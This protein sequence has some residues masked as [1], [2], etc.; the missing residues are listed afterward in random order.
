M[1]EY[2]YNGGGVAVGDVNQD[3]LP[4]IYFTAN[5]A[6]NRL[7]L[8]KGNLQFTDITDAAGVTGR[9]GPWKTGVTMADVNGDKLLDILVCYSG[10]VRPEKRLPQLFINQGPD[11]N[12][13][14]RFRDQAAQYGLTQPAYSTNASFFDYDRD[15][16]LDL[17]LLNHSPTQLPALDEALTADMLKK[18]DTQSGVRLFRN[19]KNFFKDVTQQTG[20]HSSVL[21]YGLGIAISDV[22]TDGWP[23]LYI[24]NDYAIPDFLYI[25]NHNG[26]FTNKL[27]TSVGHTSQFSMGNEVA[28]INND[29]LP[30]ILT[31]DMLPEDN[32][33]QKLLFAPDNYEKFDLNLRS[34]FY[35]QYM[36]NMLQLN[37]GDGTFSEV[38]QLAGIS[39]TDWSWA[40]LFADY[41]ND[42]WKDLYVTNGYVRDFTNLDF[43]KYMG[44]YMKQREGHLMRDDVLKLVHQMPSSNVTNY[45][46]KNT[47]N[48]VFRDES[49]NWG[50][51][52]VSNSNGAAYADLDNDGDLDLIV[53][54]INQPASIYQNQAKQQLKNQF[55]QVKLQ[56]DGKNTQGLGAKVTLYNQG[57]QQY[58]EQMPTRGFQS[59]VLPVLHFGLGTAMVVDSVQIRWPGGKQQVL[60][61]VKANQMIT[62]KEQDAENLKKPVKRAAPAFAEIKTPVTFAH[63]KQNHND[64]KRQPLLVNPQSFAGPCLIKGDVNQDG[65]EDV[66]AGGSAGQAGKLYLQQP[67]GRFMQKENTAFT[68]DKKSEDVDALFFDANQDNKPDLYVCSGGYGNFMPEDSLLQD[69]LYLGDGKGNFLKNTAAL[70]KMLTSTSCVRATDINQDGFLDLFV[71]GRVVPGRYPE[72]PRSYVL[73]NDG[74]GKFTDQTA[75]VAPALQQIGMVT[76]AAWHDLNQ[77]KIP[78]LLVVGEW[79]PVTVFKI[80][81]GKLQEA[82]ATYF[83]KNYRGWWNKIWV[84]D[85]NHDTKPDVVIGNTGLNSQ[86]KATDKQPAD[87]IYKDFDDNGSV[88]PILCFYMQGKSYPYVSRD[89]L[90]DQISMMRTRFPDYKSYADATLQD[91]FTPEEMQGAKHLSA[92]YLATAFFEMNATGK[93]V[94]KAL[95][96]EAQFAP[97]YA[98]TSLDYNHDGHLD[99]LLAGNNNQARLR[100]G[101]SDANYG[102]LLQGNGKGTFT[103]VPQTQSGLQVKGDVRSILSLKQVLLFGRNQQSVLA[104]KINGAR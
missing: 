30:D 52:H 57:Q 56:G 66:Y 26:T 99:L 55:L 49:A 93:F 33:R 29:A 9:E 21:T 12:G 68:A 24:S 50:L 71:G 16:D 82:T 74:T 6:T 4:D 72:T 17:F 81:K 19:D 38:G 75:T 51:K 60:R 96:I 32:R 61:Q 86:C 8:N 42:G 14:P 94:E 62:L 34:G 27:P 23:D 100:F 3:G 35:Y 64:F 69:R 59:S 10:N 11:S 58:L 79:M 48:A 78:E 87:L 89:E 101:K 36:R 13:V 88:D 28:D 47:G 97:V 92:N 41:D 95:P 85:F 18:E 2:F 20:L 1:Y 70:P 43:M 90:L 7:Y 76:D 102:T 44:D 84:D 25:N 54:N 98:V 65:L 39:N 15:G 37:N 73:L 31:L 40:P 63:Q 22:N 5:M 91:I 46:F 67:G 45:A 80:N 104:Y 103:Y 83:T 77:D 53:N